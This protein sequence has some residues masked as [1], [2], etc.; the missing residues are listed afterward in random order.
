M[1]R[2]PLIAII[3]GLVL[4]LYIYTSSV[5]PKRTMQKT[6][7]TLTE[8]IQEALSNIQNGESPEAQMKGVLQMRA[9]ADKHPDN[10]DLQWNMG[11]FS[12]QSG[13]YEKAVARFEKVIS[14]DAKRLNAYMQM[15]RSYSALQD[16]SSAQKV[17]LTL[18]EKSEGDLQ[19]SA[20]V[21]L[22][23]LK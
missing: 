15:A 1:K 6:Q 5:R 11:L 3:L 23:K 13:Q 18:I 4:A 8:Q 16:T 7:S 2:S 22:E 19:E 14:L 12:M 17:L 9:L 10:A 20:K 21:M